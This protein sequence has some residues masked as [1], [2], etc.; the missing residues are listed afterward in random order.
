[1]YYILYVVVRYL[2]TYVALQLV[3]KFTELSFE[4]ATDADEIELPFLQGMIS[5]LYPKKFIAALLN[6]RF[7]RSVQ[8]IIVLFDK[9]I[10]QHE[11]V[12]LSVTKIS[13]FYLKFFS[14]TKIQNAYILHVQSSK[15]HLKKK[16]KRKKRNKNQR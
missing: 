10:L 9:L 11:N 3:H 7:Q 15:S 12:N 13:I 2:Y 4:F 6:K 14:D 5:K 1:M 16:K 8:R